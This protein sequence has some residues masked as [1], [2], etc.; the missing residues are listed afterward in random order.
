MLTWL[1][2]NGALGDTPVHRVVFHEVT[3]EAVRAAMD[4]PRALDYLVGFHLS[5]VLWRKVRGGRSAGRVQSVAL[6]LLCAREA[7]IEDFAPREYW[8]VEAD[9]TAEGGGSFTARL[10]GLDGEELDRFALGTGARA[11]EAARRIREGAFEVAKLERDTVR[12]NPVPPFTTAT[13]QQEASRRLGFGVRKTMQLAQALFEGVALDGETTGLVTYM[14][15]DSV[16]LSKG[17]VSAARKIV[18]ERFGKDY[19]PRKARVFRSR[20]R[21]AQEAHEAIRPTD[22]ARTPEALEGRL[23]EDQAALY[24]LVWRRAVASQMAAAR[25]DRVRVALATAGG[26]VVL[27]ASGSTTR[28]DG[29][30]RVYREEGGEEGA[31][32]GPERALPAMAEGERAFVTEAR[33][34]QRFTRPPSRYTEADLVGQLEELGIGRPSTYAV[35]VGVLRERG[36]AVLYRRRFVPTE[37]GRVVTAF[38]AGAVEAARELRREDIRDALGSALE[39]Y[40]FAAAGEPVERA[41]PA[42]ADGELM[43][44][45]GRF[46]PF[47]SCTSF[48]DCRHSRPLSGDPAEREEARRPV[49]LGADPETGLALTLRRGRYGRYIQRGDDEGKTKALRRTVPASMEADEITPE[50]ARALLALPRIVG[51]HPETG[52]TIRAG[53]GRY[54]AWLKHGATYVPLPDDE[55]VLAVGL[56]RAVA[57][58]DARIG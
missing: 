38:F 15:T 49:V 1:E 56:N 5:P 22:L 47:V 52:K 14:R 50:L 54:G 10:S 9:V 18:R 13:L 32:T 20:A 41:C 8:S 25:L 30:L 45:L 39:R 46:G 33:S 48:P 26:D 55:D 4:H 31:G 16:A 12:R 29:F 21:N 37:R 40:L 2:E 19:L 28:F 23:G 34:A 53:I 6:R 44:K 11:E 27:A 24:A 17:A 36:Y 51:V 3:A 7:E 58:V 42:C 57:L 43:L 35:I